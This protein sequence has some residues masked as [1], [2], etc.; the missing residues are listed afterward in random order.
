MKSFDSEV[1]ALNSNIAALK[2]ELLRRHSSINKQGLSPH[3]EANV[4]FQDISTL[5]LE[6]EMAQQENMLLALFATD[7]VQDNENV[8]LELNETKERLAVAEMSC[9]LNGVVKAPQLIL[10]R[11]QKIWNELGMPSTERDKLRSQ[12]EHCL[13]GTCSKLLDEAEELK[14]KTLSEISILRDDICRMTSSL[15]LNPLQFNSSS[16]S[17]LKQLD[18]I[19]RHKSHL[20]PTMQSAIQRRQ[21]IATKALDLSFALGIPQESLDKNL[22]NLLDVKAEGSGSS[23]VSET[24]LSN[25][26]K[27]VAELQM[28]KSKVLTNNSALQN[29][30]LSK[31]KEMNLNDKDILSLVSQT[32]KRK[33][34]S[35]PFWWD[36]QILEM[37]SR[38]VTTI[39]GVVRTSRQFTQHLEIV[40]DTITKIAAVRR[41]LAGKLRSLIELAQQML[42]KTVDREFVTNSE[43]S[44]FHEEIFRLPPLSKEF[45][46]A[47]FA[48]IESL[49]MEVGVMSQSEIE[50]H[51]V[52]CEALNIS[53]AD[54]G[55]FWDTI[56]RSVRDIQG[57]NI[58]PFDDVIAL[59]LVDGEEWLYSEMKDGTKS[60]VEL[61]ARLFKLRK[62]HEEVEQ[63]R[64]R[65]D[66]KSKIMS[67]DTQ[68]RILNAQLQDF[69]DRKCNKQRLT[70]KKDTSS[71]LLKEERFRKQMQI[72]FSS[73]LGQLVSMLEAWKVN[74][75][76]SFDQ[77]LLSEDV[78]AILKNSDRNAFMHLRTVE[79]KS[80]S[81]RPA[82]TQ[83]TESEK[84]FLRNKRPKIS[85]RGTIIQ[86]PCSA[87]KPKKVES[88]ERSNIHVLSPKINLNQSDC[89]KPR[90]TKAKNAKV[91]IMT[92]SSALVPGKKKPVLDPFGNVLAQAMSPHP[93]DKENA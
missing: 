29:E 68:V 33:L 11:I 92:S 30:V 25:C 39:G 88:D 18:D 16:E 27:A 26:D 15:E 64:D 45:I 57:Q 69:E 93:S 43:I 1:D 34:T 37:V 80:A 73:K 31:V 3:E 8:V 70:T 24:F 63:L 91:S 59:S 40:H 79:Y 86:G 14:Q 6:L 5:S 52:V 21:A 77:E 23:K 83:L 60:Y 90:T 7:V 38:S 41:L 82:E 17:L 66:S 2:K 74:E 9:S 72:K 81:K 71:S 58:G 61:E 78:K 19:R 85:N 51:S 48:E 22:I 4:I 76:I 32:V 56:D 62:I 53:S 50:A 13:E 35:L 44:I 49:S 42:L 89:I 87:T 36:K 12:I 55:M 28:E 84:P 47:C 65:Q 10:E 20:N 67:L 75:S 46:C 54:R